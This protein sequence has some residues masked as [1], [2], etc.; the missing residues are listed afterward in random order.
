MLSGQPITIYGDGYQVRDVLHVHDLIDAMLAVRKAIAHTRG[1]V[2]NL[3]G[4]LNRATSVIELL[5]QLERT[6]GRPL[7]LRYCPVRPGDQPLYISDTSKLE[8]D[9]GWQP[10]RNLSD[11]IKAI[12][13]FWNENRKVI[14]TRKALDGLFEEEVA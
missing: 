3:G 11:T 10:Q 5:K 14:T 13:S 9:T 1:E 7:H 6:I 12:H 8:R 2:Y 4:G